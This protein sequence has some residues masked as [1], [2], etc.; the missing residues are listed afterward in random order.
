MLKTFGQY[1]YH[2]LISPFKKGKKSANQFYIFCHVIGK[3]FDRL[4]EDILRARAES[5]VVS[6]SPVMLPV[7]G[8]DRGMYRLR[9]ETAEGYRA[10]LALRA[11]VAEKAGTN[12][13]VRLL[14]KS[15]GYDAVEVIP[16]QKPEHWAEATVLFIGG[17][18]VLDD[19][20]LLLRELDKIKPARTLLTLSKEQ[21][22]RG[23][24]YAGGVMVTGKVM[25]MRQ[26]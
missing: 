24:I 4:R 25:E 21:R 15:F 26:M 10:R 13:G 5:M 23:V 2:L 1:M 9:D 19:R 6:A 11:I 18:I 14:A 17:K 22:Y 7:H 3:Q 12:E 20:D 8:Q 16:G